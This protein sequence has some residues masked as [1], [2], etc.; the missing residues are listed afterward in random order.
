M[1]KNSI[2]Y[3]ISS[4]DAVKGLEADTCIIILTPNT[5]EY[6]IQKNLKDEQYFN[7]EWKKL[8]VALTR[9][10]R[11]LILVLDHKLFPKH[12]MESVKGSLES[13]GISRF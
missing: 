9:T 6:F 8:Y 13:L 1:G 5:Y 12:N 10:K 7:K 3:N 11:E 4:I 2:K